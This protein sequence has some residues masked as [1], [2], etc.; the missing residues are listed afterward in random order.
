MSRPTRARL[1]LPALALV[2]FTIGVAEFT[3]TGLL[4][5]IAAAY[6]LAPARMAGAIAVYALGAVVGAPTIALLGARLPRKRLLLLLAAFVVLGNA[7]SMVAP[8]AGLFSAARFLAGLPHGAFFAVAA[9]TVVSLVPADRRGRAIASVFVGQTIATVAGVPSAAWLGQTLG[10]RWAFAVV[11]VTGCVA[12]AAVA[13]FVPVTAP[14]QDSGVRAQLAAL[15]TR[16][17]GA[18]L[19]TAVVGVGGVFA[20]LSFLAP[21]VSAG[22]LPPSAIPVAMVL[23]GVGTTV[24]AIAGG[25]F[26]DRDA[27]AA[28]HRGLAVTAVTLVFVAAT[29]GTAWAPFVDAL[30]IGVCLQL[31]VPAL[32][33]RAVDAVPSAPALGAALNQ[34]ALNGSN[35]VSTAVVGAAVAAGAPLVASPWI[36][37][38]FVA[39]G[40]SIALLTRGWSRPGDAADGP[41]TEL[42]PEASEG[43][44]Q[45]V[46]ASVRG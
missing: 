22:G 15:R 3:V 37:L 4:P 40:A 6:E 25:R 7:A 24:G 31:L 1:A 44:L 39:V 30:L 36:G 11:V 17:L 18:T 27:V 8:T 16:R 45:E 34:S 10:W 33:L 12:F 32:Q 19:A 46:T 41:S 9:A 2:A 35:A 42:V 14:A 29:M 20:V 28:T 13:V 21:I 26:A 5:D 38:A 43:E 23:F